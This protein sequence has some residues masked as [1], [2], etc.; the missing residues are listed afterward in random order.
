MDAA[1]ARVND[2]NIT[3]AVHSDTTRAGKLAVATPRTAPLIDISA[4]IVKFLDTVI[5]RICD[6]DIT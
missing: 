2:I 3:G 6:I 1:I 5:G 4:Y